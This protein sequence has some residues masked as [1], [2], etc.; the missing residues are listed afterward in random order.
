MKIMVVDDEPEIVKLIKTTF[1][2]DKKHDVLEAESGEACLDMLEK[3]EKVDLILL[4]ILM[5]GASGYDV[6]KKIKANNK[7][8]KISVVM[9]SALAHETN[10]KEGFK[11]GADEF[12]TKP[13]DPYL[14]KNRVDEILDGFKR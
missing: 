3:G 2:M 1:D 5:P 10:I 6:C 14:L 7:S 9:F 12:I 4:D 8:K 11:C 13:F